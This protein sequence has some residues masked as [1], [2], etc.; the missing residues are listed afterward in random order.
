MLK[1]A[2][3][4]VRKIFE[5]P[6]NKAI[7]TVAGLFANADQLTDD[8]KI[9]LALIKAV[10]P[11]EPAAMEKSF[12]KIRSHLEKRSVSDRR[13]ENLQTFLRQVAP[14]TPESAT[15]VLAR[16]DEVHRKSFINDLLALSLEQGE[17]RSEAVEIVRATAL[18]SDIADEEFE[19]MLQAMRDTHNSRVKIIRSGTG[20]ILALIVIGVFALIATWLSSLLFGLALA[21]IFLPLEQYFER[22]LRRPPG[23]IA[24]FLGCLNPFARWRKSLQRQ[25]KFELSA[26]EIKRREEQALTTKATTLT[27]SC[28]VFGCLLLLLGVILLLNNYVGNLRSKL[29]APATPT[30]TVQQTQSPT[31]GKTAYTA[32]TAPAGEKPA[33]SAAAPARQSWWAGVKQSV[34]KWGWVQRMWPEKP[35]VEAKPAKKQSA[36]G[37][38]ISNKLIKVLDNLKQ[39]FQKLPLIQGILNELSNYLAEGKAEKQLTDLVL[40]KSGGV[41]AFLTKFVTM[42]ATFLLNILLTFFFFSL[43]LG[44][45][46]GFVKSRDNDEKNNRNPQPTS[47]LVRTIFNGKWLPKMS[48]ENLQEGDRIVNEVINKLRIWLR[49]YMTMVAIDYCVY[50]TVFT[51]LK[52]PYAPILGAVAAVGILLPYIGPVSSALLT[53]LVTLAVGGANVSVV[54][55]AGIIGIYLL[56]NGIIEQFFIYPMVIGESLG[57]TTLETIIV[58]LLGG[59]LAGIPGMIFALPAA[60]VIKYLV[61]QIYRCWK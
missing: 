58:V 50:T 59:I 29:N 14:G 4:K 49:G 22:R 44:K 35:A 61:P 5:Q 26:E 24:R 19:N 45:L 16:M 33:V 48:E 21:Y 2:S 43:L 23:K 55:I 11:T 32:I 40:K 53:V 13:I 3:R 18:Q 7:D 8:D 27:V 47:Y 15:A 52:V 51:L 25:D 1:S 20:I 30:Q 10:L 37:E 34:R 46:A 36:L 17:Y 60:S 39:R 56:H 31:A 54:Q 12:A 28:V 57:L 9:L 38:T 6:V 42:F 41:F